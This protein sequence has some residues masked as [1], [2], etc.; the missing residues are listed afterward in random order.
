MS[1]SENIDK[2]I[3]EI[4]HSENKS[5]LKKYLLHIPQISERLD[6]LPTTKKY[7]TRKYRVSNVTWCREKVNGSVVRT[8]GKWGFSIVLGPTVHSWL[9]TYVNATFHSHS[10]YCNDTSFLEDI[11]FC[12]S[13][14]LYCLYLLY[15]V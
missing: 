8:N 14:T 13:L 10:V 11:Y 1:F 4:P 5:T 7:I 15:A 6:A 3:T 9:L 12:W 2:I